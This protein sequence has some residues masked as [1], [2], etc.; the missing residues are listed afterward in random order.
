MQRVGTPGSHFLGFG[1]PLVAGQ[2]ITSSVYLDGAT[3]G[4]PLCTHVAQLAFE[5]EFVLGAR[6]KRT[7]FCLCTAEFPVFL[8]QAHDT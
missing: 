7:T 8:K 2:F 1:P 5:K 4:V 3:E 6:F